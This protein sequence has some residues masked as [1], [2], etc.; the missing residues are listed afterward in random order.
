M[1]K[2][3][4]VRVRREKVK[5]FILIGLNNTQIA[6]RTEVTEGQ[7]RSDIK[8]I[9]KE[10]REFMKGE[11]KGKDIILEMYNQNK[12]IFERMWRMHIGEKSSDKVKL[13]SLKIILD[14]EEKQLKFLERLG[15][16]SPEPS[17]MFQNNTQNN[18]SITQILNEIQKEDVIDVKK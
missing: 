6:E 13:Q 17:I 3:R 16:I 18:I 11:E 12:E 9:T 2:K 14:T 5:K 10:N 15:M 1:A 8:A 7:I 4:D